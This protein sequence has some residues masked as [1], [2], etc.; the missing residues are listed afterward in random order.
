MTATPHTLTAADIALDACRLLDEW[1]T[2]LDGCTDPGRALRSVQDGLP[3][4]AGAARHAL[5]R[6]R[7]ERDR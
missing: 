6:H 4:I 2:Q 5:E 1:A 3:V 7:E